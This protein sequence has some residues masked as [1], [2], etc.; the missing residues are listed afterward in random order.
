MNTAVNDDQPKRTVPVSLPKNGWP[1]EVQLPVCRDPWTDNVKPLFNWS[2][3]P[4]G[5]QPRCP[6]CGCRQHRIHS[7]THWPQKMTVKQEEQQRAYLEYLEAFKTSCVCEASRASRVIPVISCCEEPIKLPCGTLVYHG[8]CC[9]SG[10]TH[11]SDAC[12]CPS[13]HDAGLNYFD[14]SRPTDDTCCDIQQNGPRQCSP[15]PCELMICLDHEDK[16]PTTHYH[17]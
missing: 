5:A 13:S 15:V 9:Y 7:E 6:G 17:W 10:Q 14:Y 11:S 12:N 16:I 1:S 3:I 4:S 2:N 8:C